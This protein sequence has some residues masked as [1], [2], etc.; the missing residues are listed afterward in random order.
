M[1][2]IEINK[3]ELSLITIIVILIISLF[4][5]SKVSN[6]FSLK[7]STNVINDNNIS[8]DDNNRVN[9]ATDIFNDYLTSQSEFKNKQSNLNSEESQALLYKLAQKKIINLNYV[10]NNIK[11]I[12][13]F[14][15]NNKDQKE[16]YDE[17]LGD[18]VLTKYYNNSDL[19]ATSS[20]D[21]YKIWCKIDCFQSPL[22]I[23]IRHR[24]NGDILVVIKDE[25]TSGNMIWS[26][27]VYN[28]NISDSIN[29]IEITNSVYTKDGQRADNFNLK[30]WEYSSSSDLLTSNVVYLP[31]DME[32]CKKLYT[33]SIYRNKLILQ[34]A[35]E[36]I[37]NNKFN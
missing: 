36:P 27:K 5:I 6:N 34:S 23:D 8:T 3:E 29:V 18:Y 19:I 12:E 16:L 24:P 11:L 30:N 21:I 26:G 9:I 7:E 1:V 28:I 31:N 35:A 2:K 4:I 33:Y 25:I 20:V 13:S 17:V 14:L 10:S 15:I 22:T 32:I 37:C